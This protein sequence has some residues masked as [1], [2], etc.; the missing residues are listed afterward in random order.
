MD[1]T[2]EPK[3]ADALCDPVIQALMEAD[4]VDVLE[5]GAVLSG[6]ARRARLKRRNPANRDRRTESRRPSRPV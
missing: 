3:L 5:L 6:A 4:G 2:G 1:W